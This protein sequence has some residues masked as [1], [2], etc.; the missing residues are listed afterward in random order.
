LAA[1]R[2]SR[3]G[4][5][6]AAIS[7]AML[8]WTL[9]WAGALSLV[10]CIP[11]EVAAVLFFCGL[12]LVPIAVPRASGSTDHPRRFWRAKG[13]LSPLVTGKLP[14]LALT[15]LLVMTAAATAQDCP[16]THD[17]LTK[18]LKAS[19]KPG[20]GPSN[21]GFDNNEWAA[22]V[23]RDGTICALTM[24][25]GAPGDQWPASRAIAAEKANTANA[26]S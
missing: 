2:C 21:G 22:I 18:A 12:A 3:V 20:G 5:V 13:R 16:A 9:L 25:G 1:R 17:Q 11:S 8:G 6:A 26:M 4:A 10:N 15:S 14:F 23:T 24:S 19:V 7:L